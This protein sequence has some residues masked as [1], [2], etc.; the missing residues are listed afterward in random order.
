MKN[1]FKIVVLVIVVS[2][3]SCTENQEIVTSNGQIIETEQF[4]T[5]KED[6]TAPDSETENPDLEED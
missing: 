4:G 2:F 3:V 5:E 1:L 6:A